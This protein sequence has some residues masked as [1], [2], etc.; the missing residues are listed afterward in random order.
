MS[1]ACSWTC[2]Q[3]QQACRCGF[4]ASQMQ[5]G[6][7][8]RPLLLCESCCCRSNASGMHNS[9]LMGLVSGGSGGGVYVLCVVVCRGLNACGWGWYRTLGANVHCVENVF[10]GGVLTEMVCVCSC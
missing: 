10:A 8:Q 6:C 3:Q 7:C 5:T 4:Q 2:Q 9:T 1:W